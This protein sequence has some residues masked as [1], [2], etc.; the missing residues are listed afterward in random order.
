MKKKTY[1]TG[2]ADGT[3]EK[4]TMSAT[5]YAPGDW[6]SAKDIDR[7]QYFFL[8]AVGNVSVTAT[9]TTSTIPTTGGMTFYWSNQLQ[10]SGYAYRLSISPTNVN[11]SSYPVGTVGWCIWPTNR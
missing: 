1:I 7:T 2:F 11:I 8:P 4:A 3:A 5:A 9:G 6:I 10:F